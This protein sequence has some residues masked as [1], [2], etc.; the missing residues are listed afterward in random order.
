MDRDNVGGFSMLSDGTTRKSKG[1]TVRVRL[2]RE[3]AI[4]T[5]KESLVA[6][7]HNMLQAMVKKLRNQNMVYLE[8]LR[9]KKTRKDKQTTI[10]M[11]IS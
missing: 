5:I 1:R 6:W 10:A 11:D 8:N 4:G 9:F 2:C 7:M 3:C